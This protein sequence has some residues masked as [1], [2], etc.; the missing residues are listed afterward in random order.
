MESPVVRMIGAA[1]LWL[2]T[3]PLAADEVPAYARD[4]RSWGVAEASVVR[5]V[6]REAHPAEVVFFNRVTTGNP[7]ALDFRLEI[8]GLSVDVSV[9]NGEGDLPDVITVRPPPGFLADPPTL[10]VHEDQTGR[11]AILYVPMS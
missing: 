8:D 11:I 3:A 10:S 9:M 5:L 6:P 1:A 7:L 4:Y 2:M